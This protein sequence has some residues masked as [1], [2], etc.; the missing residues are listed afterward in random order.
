MMRMTSE[1]KI[2]AI[3]AATGVALMLAA[4]WVLTIVL[5]GPGIADDVGARLA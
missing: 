3:S 1:Q 5:P 4:V 2:V